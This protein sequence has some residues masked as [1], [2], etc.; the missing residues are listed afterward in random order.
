MTLSTP[1][2]TNGAGYYYEPDHEESLGVIIVGAG[3]TGLASA[4][5]LR[6]AGHN[7]TVS[8]CQSV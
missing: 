1:S 2:Q 4:V 8:K 6:Q 3:I 5:A 7:V